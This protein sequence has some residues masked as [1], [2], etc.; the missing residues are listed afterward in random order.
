MGQPKALL[1]WG[2]ATLIEYQVHQLREGGVDEIVVVL[3]HAADEIRELVPDTAR[4]V[5]NL[6]FQEGRAT[7][8]RAGAAALPDDA[9][10]IVV[11]NVDQPRPGDLIS[12]LIKAAVTN[13]ALINRPVFGKEHG[14]PIVLAGSL[15][16]ELRRVE[17]ESQG[18]LGVVN[19]HRDE[20][21][22][23]DLGDERVLVDFNTPEEYK[24]ALARFGQ[25]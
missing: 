2:D 10:P 11:L 7:S 8:L 15:L 1:P 6:H 14:H 3:G 4:V 12:R 25:S 9:D 24:K 19:A 13:G 22:D 16:E 21:Q 18:L 5:V 17:E 20:M 23:I